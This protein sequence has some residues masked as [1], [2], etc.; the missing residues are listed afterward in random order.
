M[1]FEVEDRS[2]FCMEMGGKFFIGD[3]TD[4]QG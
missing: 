1:G 3:G 4:G 2:G